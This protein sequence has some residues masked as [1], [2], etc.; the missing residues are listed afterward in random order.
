MRT[1]ALF[2]FAFTVSSCDSG[3]SR[4]DPQKDPQGAV[5]CKQGDTIYYWNTG[6]LYKVACGGVEAVPVNF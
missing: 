4:P 3:P 1:L 6:R 5:A 2:L